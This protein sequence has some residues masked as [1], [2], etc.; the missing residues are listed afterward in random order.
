MSDHTGNRITEHFRHDVAGAENQRHLRPMRAASGGRALPPGRIEVAGR[1]LCNFSSND[2]LA[3][4]RDQRL[5]DRAVEWTSLYGCGSGGSRLVCGD[6]EPFARVEEKITRL[7]G[8]SA[9]LIFSSGYQANATIL[10]AL[11]QKYGY[12]QRQGHAGS[13]LIFTDRLN[14]A[15][16]H[17]GIQAA[18]LRQIRYRHNDMDHLAELLRRHMDPASGQGMTQPKEECSPACFII[19]ETV[20]SMDGDL[21]DI[22]ALRELA[23]QYDGFLY[24][25]EAH[26]IGVFGSNGLGVAQDRI[27]ADLV[28]GTFGKA[29]GSFGAYMTGSLDLRQ[30][31]INRCAGFI[32]TTA[33]PPAVLGAVDAA[34]DLLPEM[35]DTRVRIARNADILRAG[36]RNAGYDCGRSESQIV[37]VMIGDCAAALRYAAALEEAGFLVV[38]MRPPTVPK[39]TARLRLSVT[40]AHDEQDIADIITVLGDM[41]R[42]TDAPRRFAVS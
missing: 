31:L 9:S 36:L 7:G 15:S 13:P 8:A 24:L 5:I 17:A 21:A 37:P 2:Y 26:A 16:L 28:L 10:P 32:Y 25:D 4:S 42:S 35:A 41:A 19:S 6:L 12:V 23:D 27:T 22:D 30:F 20:F 40:A 18:G 34:L 1:V 29:L 11:L 38:A 33:L 39:G 3:L 14:H